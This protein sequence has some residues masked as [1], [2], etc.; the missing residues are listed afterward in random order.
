M[1]KDQGCGVFIA[2]PFPCHRILAATALLLAAG[3]PA[4]AEDDAPLT[5][6]LVSEVT[7]IQPGQPFYVGL[8]LHHGQG[9]HS[10]W[11]FP[12]V[13][14]V[15][16]NIQW[17]DLPAGFK[18]EPITWPEPQSVLMFQ[19]KAQGYER[20]VVLP[21]KITPPADL[22]DGS[23][24]TLAGKASYMVCNRQCN[25]GFEDL[26]LTLPVK[27]TPQPAMNKPWHDK[28]HHELD[29]RPRPSST[30]TASAAEGEEK[31]VLTLKPG[32]G[33]GAISAADAAKIIYFTEDGLVDSDKPQQIERLKDGSLR[34]TLVKTSYIVG[35]K[36]THI[37]G[38]LLNPPG[39]TTDGTLRC[40][41]VDA[42]LLPLTARK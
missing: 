23:R 1:A 30:W 11:E 32:I 20:D 13:V 29:L 35:G 14:G 41:R 5:L 25:P 3:L 17:K 34:F 24:I 39:W 18:A 4:L 7:S 19:I 21:I 33:A 2:M 22:K 28:I 12:G 27:A 42:A 37:T 38:V 9:W 31:I 16:T 6:R 36:P 26:S 8:A 10:Y 40:M 15:P